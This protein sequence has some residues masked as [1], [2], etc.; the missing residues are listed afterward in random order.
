MGLVLC[1]HLLLLL[2]LLLLGIQAIKTIVVGSD[3]WT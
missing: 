1:L 2:L 3:V